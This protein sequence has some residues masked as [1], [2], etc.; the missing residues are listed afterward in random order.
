MEVFKQKLR[1][2]YL[3]Y[4]IVLS[5]I[6]LGYSLFNLLFIQQGYINLNEKWVNF[7]LPITLPIIPLIFFLRP[8]IKI[9]LLK[10]KDGKDWYDFY[11]FL[12]F[13]SIVV[14]AVMAQEYIALASGKMTSLTSINQISQNPVTKYYTV[15]QI[16]TDKSQVRVYVETNVSGK[17]NENL[18]ISVFTATPLFEKEVSESIIVNEGQ[19]LVVINGKKTS[20]NILKDLKK[21][22]VESVTVIKDAAAKATYGDDGRFGVIV[23]KT[24]KGFEPVS[25][26]PKAWLCLKY[27]RTIN[28]RLSNE[29]KES[30]YRQFLEGTQ[31]HFDGRNLSNFSYLQRTGVNDDRLGFE[32]AIKTKINDE[33]ILHFLLE[34]KEEPFQ[35]R[36]GSRLSWLLGS[37]TV[38]SMVWLAL[39]MIPGI[40]TVRLRRFN[41]RSSMK[42]SFSLKP[43]K[44]TLDSLVV[45]K[46]T[47]SIIAINILIFI[48]MVFCG[49]GFISFKAQDLLIWGGNYGPKT[50]H[51]DQWWRLISCTF[52]H[53][54]LMHILFNMYGLLTVGIF[55]EPL[56]GRARY[57][58]IYLVCGFVASFTS[59]MWHPL[60]ISVGASGAIF[61]LYGMFLALLLMNVFP[62]DFK[63]AFLISSSV[64][65]GYS[66]LLGLTGGIDNAAHIGGLICGFVIGVYF[67]KELKQK[68]QENINESE[69]LADEETPQ[70]S[71][72]EN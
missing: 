44:A 47:W 28:N 49:L 70:P 72:V 66:L 14:P 55:L 21:E 63:K 15:E 69:T 13:V 27:M 68:V 26:K 22:S 41:M 10:R 61:G 45:F 16:H 42:M 35:A 62:K 7:I 43:D 12:A 8:R 6:I 30:Q 1:L 36:F 4:F 57:G 29:E 59:L 23:I 67:S 33:K 18:D 51:A 58:I 48:V 64:F 11:L 20:S 34:P 71:E 31:R 2:I 3:P 40:S 46:V 60:I 54:G 17:H 5:S 32:Q 19:P 38:G 25:Q 53:G 52:L 56:L 65:I 9:L 39:I 50:V 24:K 37:L